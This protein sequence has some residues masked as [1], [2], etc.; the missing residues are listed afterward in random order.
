MNTC[1]MYPVPRTEGSVGGRVSQPLA[2]FEEP[3]TADH[4]LM[5]GEHE[6]TRVLRE[7]PGICMA[8]RQGF[9]LVVLRR[10]CFCFKVKVN[11]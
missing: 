10:F 1:P 4:P 5:R 7:T 11:V 6:A 3:T 9:I 2:S 8:T